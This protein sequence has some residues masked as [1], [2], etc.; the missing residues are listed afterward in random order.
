MLKMLAGTPGKS[1]ILLLVDDSRV[2]T[3]TVVILLSFL[4]FFLFAVEVGDDM[5][6]VR[7]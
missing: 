3:P 2:V 5:L 6:P 4:L 7:T 1:L